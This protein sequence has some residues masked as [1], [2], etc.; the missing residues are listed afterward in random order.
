MG[1]KIKINDY[2]TAKFVS[3]NVDYNEDINVLLSRIIKYW[4][5][6]GEFVLMHEETN[7]IYEFYGDYWHGN[8]KRFILTDINKRTKT[9][10]GE[11]YKNTLQK[12]KDIRELGYNL[13][14][15]WESDWK[16]ICKSI[17]TIQQKF[18]S[19]H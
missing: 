4:K 16:K 12:E 13:V 3:M 2:E 18:K 7:T 9:T 17:R 6:Q 1:L 14:V 15:I 10:F 5:K 19:L 11:L 8:P